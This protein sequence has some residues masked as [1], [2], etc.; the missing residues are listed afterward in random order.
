MLVTLW[1]ARLRHEDNRIVLDLFLYG[2]PIGFFFAR[3]YYLLLNWPLYA[4]EPGKMFSLTGVG[5]VLDGALASI[6]VFL[7]VYTKRYHLFFGRWLDIVA[8]GLAFGHAIGLWGR[9]MNEEGFGL[10]TDSPRGF[11]IDFAHRPANYQEFDFFEPVCLYSSAWSTF[12][13]IILLAA[14][15]IQMRYRCLKAGSIFLLYIFLFSLGRF[16]F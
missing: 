8:P 12:L 7:Y 14:V 15:F 4:A 16:V 5:F 10:P 3:V 13:F 11:Y 1:Q 2:I 6:V 9:I